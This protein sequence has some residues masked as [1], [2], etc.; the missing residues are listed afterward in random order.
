MT[1]GIIPFECIDDVDE[2]VELF[3]TTGYLVTVVE[4]KKYIRVERIDCNE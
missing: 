4:A 2:L 3:K 1:K